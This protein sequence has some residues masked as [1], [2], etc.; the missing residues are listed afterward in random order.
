[1]PTFQVKSSSTI[2]RHTSQNDLLAILLKNRGL[3]TADVKDFFNPPHPKTLSLVNQTLLNKIR[4]TILDA[5]NILIYGDYDVDGITS[6]TILFQAIQKIHP[7][8]TAFIP[9]RQRDGYGFKYSSFTRFEAESNQSFDLLITVDNGIVASKDL[10]KVLKIGKKIIVIDH[11]VVSDALDPAIVTVHSTITS[12]SVLTWFVAVSLDSQA[13]LGLA[14]L[15]AVADCVP[16]QKLNRSIVYH[17][18]QSLRLNPSLGIKKL[19]E[20]SRAK[21]DSLSTYDLGYLIG[22]RINAVGRLSDPDDAFHLLSATSSS[23]ASQ[24][25]KILDNYNQDRQSLQADHLLEAEKLIK[26]GHKVIIIASKNFSPGIIGLVSGRLLEKYYLPTITISIEDGFA[27]GSCRSIPELN[28]IEKLRQLGPVFVDLGGHAGAAGFTIET[29]KILQFQKKFQ[30][31]IDDFFKNVDLEPSISADAVMKLN[32]LTLKNC[33]L[34]Q[35]LEPFGIGNEKPFFLFKDVRI[36]A[37]SLLGQNGDHLK[38]TL[39]D[40]DTK[41]PENIKADALAWKKG[42]LDKCLKVGDLVDIVASLDVNIWQN[43]SYPQL[44]VKEIIPKIL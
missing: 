10:D 37:K 17:G 39:D 21:Q 2:D 43:R 31:L 11:H 5:E 12:G 20:I 15:G 19:I 44:V 42:E 9:H 1:M 3:K 8:V 30:K 29:K 35:K 18:L 38:L 23:Q 36:T 33:Q 4:Q 13:D 24:Y 32:A 6:T 14:A 40:P 41:F 25:A 22:P 7:K 27:K 34:V 16:L 28:I 26:P